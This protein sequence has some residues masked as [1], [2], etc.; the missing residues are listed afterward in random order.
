MP[1]N[2]PIK[3]NNLKLISDFIFKSFNL[4]ALLVSNLNNI[5]YLSNFTG[6]AGIL[7][8]LKNNF[9]LFTDGR[10]T[11][12]AKNEIR[13]NIKLITYK[14]NIFKELT[15]IL[16]KH[17]IR[18]LGIEEN[19]LKYNQVK[20]ISLYCKKLQFKDIS[21][22]IL[23]FRSI[24]NEF[25]IKYIRQAL[26]IAEKSFT[27][28]KIIPG[29]SEKEIAAEL[30]YLMKKNLADDI[31]FPTIVASGKNSALPHYQ[32]GNVK[33]KKN[34]IVLIDFGAV[35]KGYHSDTTRVVFT[36]TINKKIY[37]IYKVVSEA[38]KLGINLIKINKNASEIDSEINKFIIKNG[39]RDGLIH[40]IGHGVGL[41]IHEFPVLNRNK[42]YKL[43]NNMVFTIEPGIYIE[44]LGGI[45]LENMVYLNNNKINV[46]NKLPI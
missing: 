29:K 9:F 39:Y 33:I 3:K 19:D 28:L 42:P 8:I 25:E 18:K 38:L 23:R 35:Y 22:V 43:E 5:K 11:L 26:K 1:L 16:K 4:N 7:L 17:K 21:D 40:S 37:K 36:G 41:D 44:G 2:Q 30:E 31:S 14:Q 45:R 6:D 20:S 10:Y 12:Q 13:K 46:L 15:D 34:D 32:P 24:K 27:E